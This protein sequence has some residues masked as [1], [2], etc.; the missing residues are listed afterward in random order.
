MTY[1]GEW[2]D[3]KEKLEEDEFVATG[4]DTMHRITHVG[5]VPLL[6]KDG[7]YNTLGDVLYVPSMTK[8]LASV[9]QMTDQGLQ[10]RFNRYGCFIEEFHK[11]RPSKVLARGRKKGRLFSLEARDPC[12]HS[13]MYANKSATQDHWAELWHK[14]IGHVNFRRLKHMQSN[15]IVR[16]L[17]KFGRL[18][19]DHVCE[20]CQFGKQSR[21]PFPKRGRI[22][23]SP[24]EIVHSDIWGPCVH[25]TPNG[26]RYF[27]TFTDDYSRMTW[28][29]FLKAKSKA[30][31]VFLE[32]KVMVE[33]EN[34][35]HIK[36][37]RK[38]GGGEYMS[39]SFDDYLREQSIRRQITCRYTP[40]QNGVAER[41]NRVI[42]EIA[43]AMMNEMNMPLTY[44]AEAVHTAVH[45]MNRTPTAAIH[46]IS[47]YERLYGIKPTVSYMKVFGCV[48]YVHVPNEARKKMEPKAVKCIFLGY[49]VE[50]KGYKCYD[51]TTR[52]VCVSRDV[53][54][55]EHEPWYKPKPVTIEDEYEEQEN[56]CRVV[57]ESGPSTRTI[58]GPHMTEESTGSVSPW[59]G[60]LRDKKQDE[61]GKK[62]M[63]E[64]SSGDESF[65]EKHG[66]PHLRTPGKGDKEDGE[67]EEGDEY[68][69]DDDDKDDNDDDDKD[70]NDDKDPE[71]K[72]DNNNDNGPR[73]SPEVG[74]L[75]QEPT[76]EQRQDRPSGCPRKDTLGKQGNGQG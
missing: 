70:N 3:K 72:D 10:V 34:G 33:K 25:A 45:I 35:C 31:E 21:L 20:A 51:P 62:K 4:D 61:R 27:V 19:F 57:D 37:L 36:C 16:G 8:N 75:I 47:P 54:F 43:R 17:P 5:S 71:Q 6:V 39:H 67:E 56:V 2:F 52:Q 18:N 64:E 63:F 9:G 44:W 24:L 14:R 1:H 12:L 13:G 60:R 76:E 46:E 74:A 38:D 23:R 73:E 15:Q 7:T 59:S 40:Q 30:F 53:R 22:S 50:K 68:D 29:Y 41:K 69:K 58:S 66:L 55:C 49:P 11:G 65:D 42:A 26:C 28:V 32:F 48:C